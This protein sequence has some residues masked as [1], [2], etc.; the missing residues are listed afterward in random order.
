MNDLDICYYYNLYIPIN[1]NNR[2]SKD[3]EHYYWG[4][5]KAQIYAGFTRFLYV[6]FKPMAISINLDSEERFN[7]SNE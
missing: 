2:L 4:L 3:Q 1:K 6:V 7:M 5:F